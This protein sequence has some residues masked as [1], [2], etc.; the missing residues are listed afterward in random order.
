MNLSENNNVVQHWTETGRGEK[1]SLAYQA[2]I[3]DVQDK[4]I[5]SHPCVVM[6]GEV[7]VVVLYSH[8]CHASVEKTKKMSNFSFDLELK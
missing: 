3:S 5:S 1:T 7:V 2:A 8:C 6:L 4:Q